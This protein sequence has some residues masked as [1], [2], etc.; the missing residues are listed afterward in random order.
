MV[1]I[2]M[3]LHRILIALTIV[4]FI[5]LW[6]NAQQRFEISAGISTPG[7]HVWEKTGGIFIGESFDTPD[8]YKDYTL[9]NMDR[10]AYKSTYYPSYSI[11]AAYK[12]PNHGFTKRLSVVSYVGL[13]MVDFEKIDYLSNKTLYIEKAY[14]FD[15]LVGARYHIVT[16]DLFMMYTQI[17]VGGRI[18]DGS[19]YWDSNSYLRKKPLTVQVTYLGFR[20]QDDQGRL[21][22]LAELGEGSEYSL[23]GLVLIPGVRLSLGYTF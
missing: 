19:Q 17:M 3:K 14:K 10:N 11:Q 15:V 16:K 21:C 22:F 9:A 8:P 23:G 12:L 4:S 13:D 18:F 20:V 2:M 6:L 5:P 7:D 1:L